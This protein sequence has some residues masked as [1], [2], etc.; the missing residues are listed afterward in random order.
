MHRVLQS[1]HYLSVTGISVRFLLGE[2]TSNSLCDV[3]TTPYRKL[4]VQRGKRCDQ[5]LNSV[6]PQTRPSVRKDLD[7][8]NM[9]MSVR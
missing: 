8:L 5:I 1:T 9:A 6:F 7:A 2:L 3:S 4:N